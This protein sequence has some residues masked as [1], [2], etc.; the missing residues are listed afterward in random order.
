MSEFARIK[1]AIETEKQ[2]KVQ[3]ETRIET[4]KEEAKKLMD[5]VEVVLGRRPKDLSDLN[6]VIVNK[7]SEIETAIQEIKSILDKEGV[8]Y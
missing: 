5:E 2:R 7:K 4:L 3:N 1:K 6:E 8:S